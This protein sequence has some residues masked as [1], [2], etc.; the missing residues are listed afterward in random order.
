MTVVYYCPIGFNYTHVTF[1]DTHSLNIGKREHTRDA[2]YTAW[3]VLNF[4]LQTP[5]NNGK[6]DFEQILYFRHTHNTEKTRII[7]TIKEKHTIKKKT[8]LSP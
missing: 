3:R 8:R 7:L 5:L 1:T 6:Y 2:V 4:Y